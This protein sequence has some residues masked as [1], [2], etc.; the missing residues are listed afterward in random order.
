MA[1]RVASLLRGLQALLRRDRVD[2]DLDAEL[3]AHLEMETE[4]NQRRGMPR[5]E[6]RRAA[7]LAFGGVVAVKEDCREAWGLRFFDTLAQ[8][9]RFAFRSLGKAPGFVA[10]VVATLALG[11]GANTAVLSMVNGVLLRS[12]PYAHGEGVVRLRQATPPSDDGGFAVKEL[13]DLRSQARTLAAVSEYHSMSFTLLGGAEAERVRTGVVSANYFDVLGVQPILG[14]TFAAGEDG[15]GADPVLVLTYEYWQTS[16]GGDPS[17]L[18]RRFEMNDRVHT[19]IGVLPPLPAYPDENDVYMPSSACPFRS[20]RRTIEDRSARMLDAIARIQPGTPIETVR[21]ELATIGQR[22][23]SAYPD[24]YPE[25][26]KQTTLGPTPLRDELTRHA[27]LTLLVLLGTVALVLLV[28]C[29]NVANLS[30]AR[31]ASR[32]H[33]LAVR[34]ALGAGRRRILRQ[35]VTESLLLALAGGVLGL[36]L[37]WAS[38]GL[39]RAFVARFTPRVEDVT[40]DPSVLLFTLLVAVLTGLVCGSLPGLPGADRLAAAV[41]E[42]PGRGS[43]GRASRIRGAL[44]VSQLAV[45]FVLV[46]GAALMVRTLIKL[47]QVDPGFHAD[48]VLTLSLNLNWVRYSDAGRRPDLPRIAGFY[49]ALMEPLRSRPDVTSA[50]TSW[51]FPLNSTWHSDDSFEIEGRPTAPGQPRPRTEFRSADSDYF[52]TLGIPVLSGRGFEPA[53]EARDAPDVVVLNQLLARRYWPGQDP[54]GQ[55]VSTDGGERWA[56]VV[57]VVGDVRQYGLDQEPGAEMYVP[58]GKYPGFNFTLLVRTP[59]DPLALERAV[60]RAV[61]EA[62]R[63]TPVS[64]VRTL[65]HVRSESIASPRLTMTLLSLFAALALAISAT[66]LGGALAFSVRQRKQEIGI[67]MALGAAPATVLKM[68]LAGGLRSVGLGLAIGAAASLVLAR[69]MSRLL[70]EVHPADPICFAG[71]ALLLCLVGLPATFLPARRAA[72]VDPMGALRTLG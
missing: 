20:G 64:N 67:R 8:D 23:R 59:G 5:D 27:R 36:A 57:G 33:E 35:L 48:N 4:E 47:G 32:G 62:D 2:Q 6:A 66:G 60:R 52:R 44:L 24:S 7:L 56:T 14:R 49:R 53:D 41:K 25:R 18:G 38:L 22:L 30:V 11:I 1:R 68:L 43:P 63:Q 40:I 72:R 9:L 15:P 46:I 50:A 29:A 16:H 61:R 65:D 17:I 13:D 34:A 45:S 69:L 54:V 12:L 51:T 26:L 58:F 10:A 28:A 55:R 21:A 37:A 19:V 42:G 71:S 31:L 3:A 70:F 39:L